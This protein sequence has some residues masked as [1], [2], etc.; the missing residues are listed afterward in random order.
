M[1]DHPRHRFARARAGMS[2]VADG[3]ET[4]SIARKLAEVRRDIG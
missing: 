4:A 2:V 1:E 3:I